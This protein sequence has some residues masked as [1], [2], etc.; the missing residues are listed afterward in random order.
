LA[1]G[2]GIVSKRTGSITCLSILSLY[3]LRPEI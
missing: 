3:S 1:K 2:G